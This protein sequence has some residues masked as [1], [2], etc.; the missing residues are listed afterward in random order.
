MWGPAGA[1]GSKESGNVPIAGRGSGSGAGWVWG[2][3][4]G[5]GG[6]RQLG[7]PGLPRVREGFLEEEGLGIY[8]NGGLWIGGRRSLCTICP[9]PLCV[10]A[11]GPRGHG[12]S[13]SGT[14]GEAG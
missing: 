5:Q 12:S 8:V 13:T 3:G 1:G 6:V 14:R 10:S 4:L 9:P 2:S 7:E 11:R